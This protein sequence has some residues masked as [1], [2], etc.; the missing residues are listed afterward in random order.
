MIIDIYFYFYFINYS[1]KVIKLIIVV[2]RIFE[3]HVKV[4]RKV[5]DVFI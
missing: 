2:I 4:N 1:I 5:F 3:I